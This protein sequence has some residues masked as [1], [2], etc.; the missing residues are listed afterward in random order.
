MDLDKL[1]SELDSQ[2]SDVD[3]LRDRLF[4]GSTGVRQPVHTVYV[5]AD[6]VVPD[7][8]RS[9]GERA[10]ASLDAFAS[11]AGA[12]T[13][14]TGVDA[15][16]LY[17]RVRAKLSTEPIEDLRID[18]EDGYGAPDDATED[19]HVVEVAAVLAAAAT[20]FSGVRIKGFEPAV[21]RRG[22]RTL[23]LLLDHLNPLPPNFVI[24]LPKV[25][26]VEQVESMV[27]LCAQLERLPG[28]LRFEL[29]IET[30]QAVLGPDGAATVAR[31]IHASD[32]RCTALHYGTYD[33][34]AACGVTAAHQSMAHP[35]ADHAKNIMLLAAAG[36]GVTVSDGSTN[37][38]P[39]GDS[40]AVHAGWRLHTRLV[41]RSL[42]H[43]FYQGWDLHPHQLP[44][45]YLATFSFY[46]NAF[47]QAATRLNAY[48]A[49]T[50]GT[51]LDEPATAQAMSAA[52]VRGI[53]CGALDPAEVEAA[54]GAP[55]SVLDGFARRRVG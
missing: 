44:T 30:T 9:W 15:V 21:R 18:F 39:V 25:T 46:R 53:D 28:E 50:A 19:R 55:R 33:Y 36:T 17:D 26:S 48:L 37:I 1:V 4:P 12:F 7:L 10:L 14:A 43:A 20:P 31:M 52:L 41:T 16:G 45:R 38:L 5:P 42:E 22:V 47:P 24:T 27:W 13:G 11:D 40:D 51:F 3:A 35:V 32:G 8:A 2:L 49:K 54:V 23:S 34:S 29:Q 6:Q